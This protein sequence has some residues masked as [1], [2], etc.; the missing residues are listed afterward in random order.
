MVGSH[1]VYVA[2]CIFCDSL[3]IVELIRLYLF[4]GE[5]GAD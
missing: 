2:Q 3:F 5:A 4:A 1:K